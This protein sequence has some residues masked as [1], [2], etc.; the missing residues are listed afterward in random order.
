MI[1]AFLSSPSL[2][3]LKEVPDPEPSEDEVVISV[4]VALT[5]GT[6]LK[7][8]LRGHNLI[9]MPGP[10][11][12]EFSGTVAKAGKNVKRF[13]EGDEVM[14]VHSAPCLSCPYCERGLF[15]LC[16]RI[17][18]RKVL[19]AYSEYVL[20][21]GHIVSQNVYVKPTSLTHEDAAFLEPLSC[22][23]HPYRK[24]D[25]D[26]IA[27]VLVIGAGPIGLLHLEVLM[28]QG[29]EVFVCD[30]NSERLSLARTLGAA[31]IAHPEEMSLLVD[32]WTRNVRF[33]MVVECTGNIEVW[34]S[35]IHLVRRGGIVILFGGCEKGSHVR[36]P[37][38]RLHY[39]ELSLLGSFHFTPEDVM[40]AYTLL[41][42]HCLN[43]KPFV[44]GH[45]DLRNITD[46][47]RDLS[48]GKGIKYAIKP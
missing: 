36:Y 28:K 22:V 32:D 6:D 18:E 14:A 27:N 20:L 24:V 30:L 33:D 10:F 11:G 45:Y 12:H 34:E 35:S 25:I 37:A 15:N 2:I 17:M 41:T 1:Q 31:G 4:K 13:S 48:E 42:D 44:T 16:Q 3:E 21:P 26:Q 46:A 7:A 5:C 23:V 19:G 47:F 38:D 9:P 29:I 40:H 43:L 8:Y 39:D